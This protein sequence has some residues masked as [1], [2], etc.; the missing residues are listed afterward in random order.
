MQVQHIGHTYPRSCG[1]NRKHGLGLLDSSMHILSN[2]LAHQNLRERVPY[3]KSVIY[4]ETLA[5][6]CEMQMQEDW[7]IFFAL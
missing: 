2:D 5:T 3:V 1:R 4:N 7:F 6:K